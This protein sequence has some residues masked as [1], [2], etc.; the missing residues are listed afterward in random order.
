ML[1]FCSRRAWI[2][3]SL[4][5]RISVSKQQKLWEDIILSTED[6]L[7]GNVTVLYLSVCSGCI[8]LTEF[9]CS[10]R[11]VQCFYCPDRSWTQLWLFFYWLGN[12]FVNIHIQKYSELYCSW[13]APA[14]TKVWFGRF[15]TRTIIMRFFNNLQTLWHTIM[16][17]KAACTLWSTQT[18]LKVF[19]GTDVG[20]G[21]GCCWVGQ[22]LAR[23]TRNE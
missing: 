18:D 22:L 8:K 2:M 1:Q 10:E 21:G 12:N 14:C 6:S 13:S 9:L 5:F 17:W 20:N 16:L 7:R 15:L 23:A 4:A 11:R 3:T 19:T